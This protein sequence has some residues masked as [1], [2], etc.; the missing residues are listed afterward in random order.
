MR[1]WHNSP[2]WIRKHCN[3]LQYIFLNDCPSENL[4]HSHMVDRTL[5][6]NYSWLPDHE[7]TTVRCKY[8]LILVSFDVTFPCFPM[9]FP[10]S[11]DLPNWD[12]KQETCQF[13]APF[14][15]VLQ[16]TI[17]IQITFVSHLTGP[18]FTVSHKSFQCQTSECRVSWNGAALCI[19]SGARN[20]GFLWCW[21]VG[22]P[23][24]LGICH[25]NKGQRSICFYSFIN[26]TNFLGF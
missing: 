23:G 10:N 21:E 4:W 22:I 8:D 7:F 2:N 25:G 1:K 15:L 17:I 6:P 11:Q 14:L 13:A 5:I 18:S 9:L 3:Y 19:C 20:Q 12:Q 16:E 24:N 26:S